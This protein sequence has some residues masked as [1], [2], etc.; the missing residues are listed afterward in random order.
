MYERKDKN[1]PRKNLSSVPTTFISVA[2]P[3]I[4]VQ[5][6]LFIQQILLIAC[7]VQHRV[8]RI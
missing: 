1:H 8:L 7:K 4:C 3:P 6:H 5:G 2:F